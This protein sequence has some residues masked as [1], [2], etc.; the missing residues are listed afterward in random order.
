MRYRFQPFLAFSFESE[1]K[2]ICCANV[3]QDILSKFLNTP[4]LIPQKNNFAEFTKMYSTLQAFKIKGLSIVYTRSIHPFY[5]SVLLSVSGGQFQEYP[6]GYSIIGEGEGVGVKSPEALKSL[7]Y[8]PFQ[9]S[10]HHSKL[11]CQNNANIVIFT[12]KI[13][14]KPYISCKISK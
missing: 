4:V 11:L 1:M 3:A 9:R 10:P 7:L 12:S 8:Q 14:N 5:N 2:I 6:R 13:H